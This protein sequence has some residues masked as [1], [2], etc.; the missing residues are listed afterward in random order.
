MWLKNIQSVFL[1]TL[2][3]T[4]IFVA[5][6]YGQL[7]KRAKRASLKTRNKQISRFTVRTDFS[8]SKKYI[9]FGGGA[10]IS[11]YFGDLAP[12]SRRGS[13]DL[14]YTRTYMTGF[15]LHRIHPHITIRGALTWMRLRGDDYSV[16]DVTNPSGDDKGRF[17]RNL[18]FRN[19]I[20]EVSGVGI[21]ELFPTDRGF[22]RRNFINPYGILGLSVF[23]HNP[24][25]KTPI[26]SGVGAEQS[27]WVDLK[28]LGTEGQYTG[29]PGTPRPY[30][31]IQIGIP[32][33]VGV[34]YRLLDKWDLSF[35]FCYR[36]VFTDYVDDVSGKYPAD[37]VYKK[38]LE[39][40]NELGVI[41]SN[42][43]AE[44]YASVEGA[45]RSDVFKRWKERGLSTRRPFLTDEK[46]YGPFSRIPGNE[47]GAAPRGNKRR[48]YWL[49]TAIHLAYILEIKQKPPKFR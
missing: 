3:A 46:E 4:L 2:I 16:A 38:M 42:R 23:R 7:G 44:D 26:K 18:S 32:L 28:P 12:R 11:N 6:G 49:C 36:F 39:D 48:D 35:E 13:S 15:Y 19:D 1:V 45:K 21:F 43:S 29:I 27:K 14:G 25:T 40:G 31:L 47:N 34:R 9:S 41:L 33:G 10:G 5:P 17:T 20:F 8:K 24:K 22:L 37:T 30:S